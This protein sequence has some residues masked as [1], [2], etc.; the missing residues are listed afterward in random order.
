PRPELAVQ[1]MVADGLGQVVGPDLLA[2]FKVRND[3]RHSQKPVVGAS[4][5]TQFVHRGLRQPVA[6]GVQK[7]EAPQLPAV[8][9]LAVAA[10]PPGLDRSGPQDLLAHAGAGSA[11]LASRKFLV[12]HGRDLDVY[13]DTVEQRPADQGDPSCSIPPAWRRPRRTR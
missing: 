12:G 2:P 9:A 7:A 10:E 3:T 13:V 1:A 5:E 8:Q 6:L 4:R 11:V